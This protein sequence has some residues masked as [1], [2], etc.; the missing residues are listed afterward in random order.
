MA[1][2]WVEEDRHE[3]TYGRI[4]HKK[5]E[6]TIVLG[7]SRVSY[8]DQRVLNYRERVVLTFSR[9]FGGRT[10]TY[11]YHPGVMLSALGANGWDFVVALMNVVGVFN[12]TRTVAKAAMGLTTEDERLAVAAAARGLAKHGGEIPDDLKRM[13]Q[14][15]N[16][17]VRY[18]REGYY[19]DEGSQMELLGKITAEDVR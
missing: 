17:A 1:S 16:D 15:L 11:H 2:I 18:P 19:L 13:Y 10:H 6:K 12:K 9:V 3:S 4:V 8:L 7:V 5:S 14:H